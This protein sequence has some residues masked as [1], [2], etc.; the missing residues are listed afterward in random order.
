MISNVAGPF[1]DWCHFNS[2]SRAFEVTFSYFSVLGSLINFRDLRD[3]IFGYRPQNKNP[4]I[5][6]NLYFWFYKV[7]M[8]MDLFFDHYFNFFE[9]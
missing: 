8:D 3:F 7:Q 6:E 2:I 5:T 9:C 1:W 4:E